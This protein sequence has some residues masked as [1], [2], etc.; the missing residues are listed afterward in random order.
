MLFTILETG[1]VVEA[2]A[3]NKDGN[4]VKVAAAEMLEEMDLPALF[5]IL[6]GTLM[7][8]VIALLS[9]RITDRAEVGADDMAF[10]LALLN[11][12]VAGA[13]MFLEMARPSDFTIE[14]TAAEGDDVI[15]LAVLN[16]LDAVAARLLLIGLPLVVTSDG[17]EY[18]SIVLI[19]YL[20]NV[21]GTVKEP[22]GVLPYCVLES[23]KVYRAVP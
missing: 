22:A 17:V 13:V 23:S 1:L 5:T 8:F 11:S 16:N 7:L 2:I 19:R 15:F 3:L 10:V 9:V 14:L 4:L 12:I 18:S 6:A 21:V 20:F